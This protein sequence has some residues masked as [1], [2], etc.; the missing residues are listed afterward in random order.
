MPLN[1]DGEDEKREAKKRR[2]DHTYAYSVVLHLLD[3]AP[4]QDVQHYI[5]IIEFECMQ[6]H[7]NEESRYIY[8]CGRVAV[9]RV[10]A[11]QSTLDRHSSSLMMII[12]IIL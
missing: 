5:A 11:H 10:Q 4:K 6:L 12:I 1:A 2:Y 8:A 7:Y 9:W 3:V